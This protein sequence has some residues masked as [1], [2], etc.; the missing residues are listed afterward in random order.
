M[1]KDHL[2]DLI[3][4]SPINRWEGL[5]KRADGSLIDLPGDATLEN[6]WAGLKRHLEALA[7]LFNEA[8]GVHKPTDVS[9]AYVAR[10]IGAN[11]IGGCNYLLNRQSDTTRATDAEALRDHADELAKEGEDE[12]LVLTFRAVADA[13]EKKNTT[14]NSWLGA[15]NCMFY[16]ETGVK[17]ALA[18]SALA[19]EDPDRE[20]YLD[21]AANALGNNLEKAQQIAPA[22]ATEIM[23]PLAEKG[24]LLALVLDKARYQGSVGKAKAAAPSC[25]RQPS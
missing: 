15:A 23:V 16:L 6:Q 21:L 3:E 14:L 19:P 8:S 11:G 17:A 10:Q 13:L 7:P 5:R 9:L 1:N 24:E 12:S 20:I 25:N 2:L 22:I 18:A 4:A